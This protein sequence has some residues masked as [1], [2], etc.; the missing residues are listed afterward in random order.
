[1][2]MR[3]ISAAL[4]I[5]G[6][7]FLSGRAN[8][9]DE[10]FTDQ[11]NGTIKDTKSN[12]VWMKNGNCWGGLSWDAA[13]KAI[14]DLNAGN[15]TCD[16]YTGKDTLWHLP[17]KD[18]LISLLGGEKGKD[19]LVLPEGHPFGN[20]Q[21]GHYWSATNADKEGTAWYV[22]AT[23]GHVDFYGKQE[24]YFTWPVQADKK[25]TP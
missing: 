25:P 2:G 6:M 18:E 11:G 24:T 20:V 4:L 15:K 1:M 7:V 21:Q 17:T 23:N 22:N 13:G 8:S 9:A 14:E 3:F 19:G 16:G 10:R 12:L 5:T